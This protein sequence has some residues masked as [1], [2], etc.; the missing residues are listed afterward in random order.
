MGELGPAMPD[1]GDDI[2]DGPA[3]GLH[4]AVIDLAHENEPAGQI[5]ANHRLEPLGR[6]GFHRRAILT[7]GIV[8]EPVDAAVG[9]EHGIDRRDHH[10]LI[11]DIANLGQDL[12]AVLLDLRL[13]FRQFFGGAAED[14]DISAEGHQLV[15]GATADA[16]AAAGDD[17][18][19][20]LEEIRPE[21]RLIRHRVLRVTGPIGGPPP[22]AKKLV[23]Y[24]MIW[25][26]L[27]RKRFAG[28]WTEGRRR[29]GNNR[30]LMAIRTYPV[31]SCCPGD[32]RCP[33]ERTTW[34]NSRRSPSKQRDAH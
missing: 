21:D 29:T 7:T 25:C 33:W 4:P 32:E 30:P 34:T 24:I 12:P 3:I 27:F 1:V 14:R 6:D 31:T 5:A 26:I 28:A 10:R 8:D 15:C 22:S 2:D 23:H 19:L 17:D 11:A 13:H 9:T 18:R 16:A 20:A